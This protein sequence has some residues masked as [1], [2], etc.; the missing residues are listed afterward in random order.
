M[1]KIEH[2]KMGPIDKEK[3]ADLKEAAKARDRLLKPWWETKEDRADKGVPNRGQKGASLEQEKDAYVKQLTLL[4]LKGQKGQKGQKGKGKGEA[5]DS[6][7][8]KASSSPQ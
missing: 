3:Y 5:G 8:G 6:A 1:G 7:Q 4:G 2:Q